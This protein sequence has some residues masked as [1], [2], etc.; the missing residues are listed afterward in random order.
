[1]ILRINFAKTGTMDAPWEPFWTAS[2]PSSY[3]AANITNTEVILGENFRKEQK[4]FWFTNNFY[5]YSWMN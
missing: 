2:N 4:E 3:Y 5:Y 1:M